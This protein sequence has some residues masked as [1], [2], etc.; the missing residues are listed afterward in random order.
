MDEFYSD[1]FEIDINPDDPLYVISVVSEMVSIPI[2]T[3]RKLDEMEV[4]QPRRLG[5]KTRCYSQKQIK[6]L[7]YVYYLMQKKGVN[8]SG[9]KVILELGEGEKQENDENMI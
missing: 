4:V 5:K 2:W 8:I 3:L 9:V 7:S 1:E 6:K